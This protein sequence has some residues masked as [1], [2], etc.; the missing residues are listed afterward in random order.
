MPRQV[1]AH[2]TLRRA[3][4]SAGRIPVVSDDPVT[5]EQFSALLTRLRG[6]VSRGE[7]GRR[8]AAAS[9][10]TGISR[11]AVLDMER[12]R[13]KCKTCGGRK[14]RPDG[15]TCTRCDDNGDMIANP[16][17]QQLERLGPAYGVRFEVVAVDPR[18]GQIVP[19][20]APA[21]T[22]RI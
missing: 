18:N 12:G 8:V 10:G 6:T 21:F 5:R 19:G 14:R 4:T 9:G 17:L 22:A 1:D 15:Q 13:G 2:G 7:V 3:S 16:T 11:Q 20:V